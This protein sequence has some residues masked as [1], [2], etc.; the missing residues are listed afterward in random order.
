MRVGWRRWWVGGLVTLVAGCGQDSLRRADPC[1]RSS[2]DRPDVATPDELAGA[3]VDVVLVVDN[4]ASMAQEIVSLEKS[5][6]ER[7]AT[8]LAEARID[9]RVILISRHG[10]A[11]ADGGVCVSRPLSGA[12]CRPVPEAPALTSR[13]FHFSVDV[14][15]HDRWCTTLLSL[16]GQLEDDFALAASGFRTW[17]RQ[18]AS[19]VF[20]ELGDDGADCLYRGNAFVDADRAD[21]GVRVAALFDESLRA[22][23]PDVLGATADERR[24]VWHSVVG[25]D[26]GTRR[27]PLAPDAPIIEK[28][29]STAAGP[30]TASQAF[31]KLTGGLRYAAAGASFSEIFADVADDIVER[32]V[33]DSLGCEDAQ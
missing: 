25:F 17:L 28:T 31:A 24:Y 33:N 27:L 30:G 26:P 21:E 8:T 5:I 9:Y 1:L 11:Q 22:M 16:Q 29:A 14:H 12:S 7:F 10:D 20:I 3:R 32:S 4:S 23:A 19:V 13:F 18:D 15:S 2:S 6:N